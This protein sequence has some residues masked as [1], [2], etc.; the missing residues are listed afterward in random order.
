MAYQND[1]PSSLI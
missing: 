1:V